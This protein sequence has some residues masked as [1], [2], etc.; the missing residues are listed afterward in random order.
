MA[1]PVSSAEMEANLTGGGMDTLRNS[2]DSKKLAQSE[3]EGDICQSMLK[4]FSKWYSGIKP[5]LNKTTSTISVPILKGIPDQSSPPKPT[6]VIEGCIATFG[7]FQY[8]HTETHGM[9]ASLY[10]FQTYRLMV[11]E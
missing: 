6:A 5:L 10:I 9:H 8:N 11:R 3:N 4:V 7:S 1:N 2:S